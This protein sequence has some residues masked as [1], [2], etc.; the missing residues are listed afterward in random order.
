MNIGEV[1]RCLI[2]MVYTKPD[3]T[4]HRVERRSRDDKKKEAHGHRRL[5]SGRVVRMRNKMTAF[6]EKV[7]RKTKT[8]LKR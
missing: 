5:G 4:N 3:S 1:S 6:V 7:S 2:D 8:V